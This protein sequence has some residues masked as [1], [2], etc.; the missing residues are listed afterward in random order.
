ME[1]RY[2]AIQGDAIQA[3]SDTLEGL[4]ATLAKEGWTAEE[5]GHTLTIFHV[6]EIA[7]VVEVPDVPFKFVEVST[8]RN[9]PDCGY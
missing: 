5:V 9:L 8:T 4:S 3:E 6:R 7:Y 1:V 2:M